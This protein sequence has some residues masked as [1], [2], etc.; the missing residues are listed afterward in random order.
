MTDQTQANK[1]LAARFFEAFSRGEIANAATLMTNDSH[2]TVMGGL[3][4]MSGVYARDAF[5]DL[6]EGAKAFYRSGAL[7]ITPGI[8]TAE[9]DR[10]SVI[11]TGHAELM[12]GRT[13]EPDYHFLLTF[14]DGA[15]AEVREYMD[16]LH[17][18]DI[19]FGG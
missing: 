1:K 16:T 13:Y 18:K 5:V 8:M 14:R 7:R 12:D 6:A 4:G 2:W 3:D 17:A 19:F 11:A 15:I 9:D 10:V